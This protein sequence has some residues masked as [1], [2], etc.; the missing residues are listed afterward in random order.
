[1]LREMSK[2]MKDKYRMASHS[3]SESKEVQHMKLQKQKNKE[4]NYLYNSVRAE[5]LWP[6]S[7][8]RV[9][10]PCKLMVL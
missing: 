9:C 4:V 7:G 3:C 5:P 6:S 2:E 8:G 10:L 1:M